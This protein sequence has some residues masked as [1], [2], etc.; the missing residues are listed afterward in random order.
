MFSV[1]TTV[2]WTQ[3]EFSAAEDMFLLLGMCL[4]ATKPS[5]TYRRYEMQGKHVK[6]GSELP[7]ERSFT[8]Y[9]IVFV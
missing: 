8:V 5:T 1:S 7:R 4:S 3:R 9:G 6:E 2:F